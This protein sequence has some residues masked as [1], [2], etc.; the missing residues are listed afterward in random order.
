MRAGDASVVTIADGTSASSSAAAIRY[1]TLGGATAASRRGARQ[2]IRAATSRTVPATGSVYGS[3]CMVSLCHSRDHSAAAPRARATQ[4]RC[5]RGER[6]SNSPSGEIATTSAMTAAGSSTIHG[7]TRG[8]AIGVTR[9]TTAIAPAPRSDASRSR[10]CPAIANASPAITAASS[11]NSTLSAMAPSGMRAA[12]ASGQTIAAAIPG[13]SSAATKRSE[14][15]RAV[16]RRETQTISPVSITAPATAIRRSP[17]A[18][19]R[20]TPPTPVVTI[21]AARPV[22]VAT[23][24]MARRS[25]VPRMRS[26]SV[27]H[28]TT[29]SAATAATAAA[30]AVSSTGA[31]RKS[32]NSRTSA[33][34]STA[35]IASI[36]ASGRMRTSPRIS[37]RPTARATIASRLLVIHASGVVHEAR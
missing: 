21:I 32:P 33:P 30:V 17:F 23:Q 27:A 22:P 2:W 12:A 28:S 8:S 26:G 5:L 34:A 3:T 37:P 4:P 19:S 16:P 14:A 25:R 6:D 31:A 29:A 36:A 9:A 24:N 1:A 7:S 18:Y 11:A 20:P 13:S 35:P 10:P 15:K